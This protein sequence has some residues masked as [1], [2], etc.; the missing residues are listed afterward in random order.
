MGKTQWTSVVLVVGM[1][2]SPMMSAADVRVT[3]QVGGSLVYSDNLKQA[4]SDRQGS[5][6]TTLNA[7]VGIE[8]N[9]VDGNALSLEYTLDQLF[10]SHDGNDNSLYQTLRFDANKALGEG[11]R[12]DASASID[13]IAAAIDENANADIFTGDTV[14]NKQA[15]LGVS[16]R[17][18]PLSDSNVTGRV[19]VTA[20]NYEDDIGNYDG[21][22][23]ALRFSNGPNV[24]DM[25]WVIE[26]TYDYKRSKG[27]DPNTSFVV[28]REEI[29][30]QTVYR[31]VPF[32]RLN[33]ENYSGTSES[34]SADQL[35]WGPA[36]RYFFTKTSYL[37]VSYNFSE[38]DDISDFWAGAV[39]L[40]PSP[41]TSLRASYDKRAFGD[42]YDFLFSHRSRRLTNE[43]SY[44]EAVT[45]YDR[46]TFVRDGN[47]AQAN[48]ER[49]LT[50][51][52]I[53]AARRTTYVFSLYGFELDALNS[54]SREGDE[55]GYGASF[56]IDHQL[57]RRLKGTAV[58]DYRDYT[59]KN[60]E[61]ADQDDQYWTFSIDGS[62]TVNA[63]VTLTAGA[64]HNNKSSSLANNGYD[65]NRLYL[66][67][68]VDL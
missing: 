39:Y 58:I 6:I 27:D 53:L 47:I 2:C 44:T 34:D 51:E 62:Y 32:M 65:E 20:S 21:G 8:A 1:G 4:D 11:F 50:W 25:F 30:F 54:P 28:L 31:W 49:R 68:N 18:N 5:L 64:E 35:S 10:Y 48:V 40:N 61:T 7:G 55:Q 45:N 14:E 38:T 23:A 59:F 3:P 57:S 43:I 29:G 56:S 16:Y 41:R 46:E 19:F 63:M 26:G 15:E 33:Y 42:A 13:N 52:S 66:E 67:L 12:L 17:S 22:G 60:I 36:L 37:E 24:R 9:G